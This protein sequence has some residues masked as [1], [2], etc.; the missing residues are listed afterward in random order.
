MTEE[1]AA[2]ADEDGTIGLPAYHEVFNKYPE[3]LRLDAAGRR[4]RSSCG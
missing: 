1:G 4:P 3:L 2:Y